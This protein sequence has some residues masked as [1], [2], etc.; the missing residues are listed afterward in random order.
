M[1]LRYQNIYK[2]VASITFGKTLKMSVFDSIFRL[3]AVKTT[4]K[5]KEWND[6][7]DRGEKRNLRFTNI[8]WQTERLTQETKI[9]QDRQGLTRQPFIKKLF[10]KYTN[11]DKLL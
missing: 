1:S 3:K 7:V 2:L 4:L 5:N 11:I 6:S 9:S 10:I 8:L